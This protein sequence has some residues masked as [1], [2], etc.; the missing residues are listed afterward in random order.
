MSNCPNPAPVPMFNG[1][2]LPPLGAHYC[3]DNYEIP[4]SNSI[5]ITATKFYGLTSAAEFHIAER[6]CHTRK[7]R[8]LR[9][10]NVD[11]LACFLDSFTLTGK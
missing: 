11:E 2:P 6:E 4:A 9:I 8:M 1:V 10:K 3:P 7:G 5:Q